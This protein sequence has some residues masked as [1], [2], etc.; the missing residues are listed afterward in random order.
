MNDDATTVK[1]MIFA[2]RTELDSRLYA[3]NFHA[4]P[5][6]KRSFDRK[7]EEKKNKSKQ[8]EGGFNQT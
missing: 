5:E 4:I 2:I 7:K 6:K 1:P 3:C 8:L